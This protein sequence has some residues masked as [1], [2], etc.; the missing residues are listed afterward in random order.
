MTNEERAVIDAAKAWAA[1]MSEGL[2]DGVTRELLD[3]VEAL[4]LAKPPVRKFWINYQFNN[5]Q[6]SGEGATTVSFRG[7]VTQGRVLSWKA[8]LEADLGSG[9]G[10]A[11]RTFTEL[12]G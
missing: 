7:S 9:A 1:R 4:E 12:E 2:W 10:V 6:G 3:T 11:I 5:H 8:S